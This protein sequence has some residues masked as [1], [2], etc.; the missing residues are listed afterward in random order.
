MKPWLAF[1]RIWSNY[2][3][4]NGWSYSVDLE[5]FDIAGQL[6]KEIVF[7]ESI[8]E[9]IKVLENLSRERIIEFLKKVDR[10]PEMARDYASFYLPLI[11]KN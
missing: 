3:Q 6:G 2:L 10:W 4:K 1:F 7:L 9:Q 8:E 11:L 5:G